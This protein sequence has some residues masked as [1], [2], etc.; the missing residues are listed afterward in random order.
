V[1]NCIIWGNEA[2][3][4]SQLDPA[5]TEPIYCCVEN[6]SSGGEGNINAAPKFVDPDGPDND[7][8]T[9]HDN[10]YRLVDGS[11]CI[12][13]GKTE[14]WM[15]SSVDLDGN[16]RVFF[17]GKSLTVDMGAYEY[18]SFPFR[19]VKVE[20]T[21][22]GEQR[23]TWTSRSGDTYVV[24]SSP[25][26]PGRSWAEEKTVESQGEAT[27]WTDTAG[28]KEEKFYKIELR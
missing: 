27:S 15:W 9:Y 5:E 21:S 18:G 13:V 19:I 25:V 16:P 8:A 20:E 22:F 4:H 10:D 17:G 11:K 12:D 14:M 1:Q 2:L 6:W 24:W 7:P 23:I 28:M 3:S 26:L